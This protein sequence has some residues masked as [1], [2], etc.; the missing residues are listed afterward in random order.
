MKPEL[1]FANMVKIDM[2]G[3]DGHKGNIK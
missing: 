3:C 1:A 2:C